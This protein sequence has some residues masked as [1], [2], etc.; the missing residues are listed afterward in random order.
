MIAGNLGAKIKIGIILIGINFMN[1]PIPFQT[2]LD[3][4]ETGKLV[5]ISEIRTDRQLARRLLGL[6]IR[7]GSRV[8]VTQQ[9]DKGVVVACDGNRV[10]LGGT[11][12]SK[13]F[14]QPMNL[15]EASQ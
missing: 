12:A 14:T 3:Q 5:C 15:A 10:A 7:V 13:L 11:V 8:M 4:L 9:R 6:G 1:T 2:A